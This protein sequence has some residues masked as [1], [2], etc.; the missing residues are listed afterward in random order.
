MVTISFSRGSSHSRDQTL[1][2]CLASRF[3]T[4]E[5]PAK[6]PLF[7]YTR[8]ICTR[9]S[10][11]TLRASGG[12]FLR[13][14]PSRSP[15][16]RTFDRSPGTRGL[17]WCWGWDVK[18]PR[19]PTFLVILPSVFPV[20]VLM[21]ADT[22]TLSPGPCSTVWSENKVVPPCAELSENF[23]W[24]FSLGKW[25]TLRCKI[26]NSWGAILSTTFKI[27]ALAA[28]GL[29]CGTWGLSLRH[30]DSLAVAHRLCCSTAHGTLVP[31]PT[32]YWHCKADS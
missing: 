24:F 10:Y 18:E 13:G 19:I 22:S 11:R 29:S 23:L 26:V 32:R 16:Q 5:P 30:M 9:S 6:P 8:G 14:I 31:H 7:V 4:T 15:P 21:D 2:S 27:F 25:V 12:Q 20:S 28:A 17:Q 3:F 1:F